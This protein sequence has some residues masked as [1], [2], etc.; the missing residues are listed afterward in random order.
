MESKATME[1]S[2][3][4]YCCWEWG[5]E[6]QEKNKDD[7]LFAVNDLVVLHFTKLQFYYQYSAMGGRT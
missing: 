4:Y 2:T 6:F 5:I 1:D 3:R 7:G